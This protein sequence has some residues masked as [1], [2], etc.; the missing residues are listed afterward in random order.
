MFTEAVQFTRCISI[1]LVDAITNCDNEQ[2]VEP[3]EILT[4]ERQTVKNCKC[5]QVVRVRLASVATKL[6][7]H[8]SQHVARQP[9]QQ[10][11]W[12]TNL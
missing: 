1:I 8:E 9:D 5:A 2:T 3:V 12:R 7:S 11:N 4:D 6:Q 10:H